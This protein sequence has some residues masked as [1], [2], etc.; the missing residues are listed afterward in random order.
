MESIVF[1]N[2]PLAEY[3]EGVCLEILG[4]IAGCSVELLG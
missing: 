1:A 3:L 2:S 4:L